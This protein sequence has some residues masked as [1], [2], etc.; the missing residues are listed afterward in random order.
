MN[1]T[2][3]KLLSLF[4]VFSLVTI[5][6]ASLRTTGGKREKH[7]A[8]LLIKKK[9]GQLIEGELITVKKD[10]LLLLFARRMDV[11]VGIE[12]IKV[13]TIV[14]K[15][16]ALLGAGLGFLIGGAAGALLGF[17]S[18]DDDPDPFWTA[19]QIAGIAAISYGLV[20]LIIG[21]IAGLTSGIDKT[22][23]I[24]GMSD[25]EIQEALDKLRKKARIR[26]YK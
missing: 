16:K 8:K 15:S 11:S 24:E 2:S 21:G 5:N 7:G 4:L 18:A 12:E 1:P 3:K 23:Q 26:D 10:S 6:C 25:S 17:A 19:E 14:K 9:N 22:I 20:G 13:I